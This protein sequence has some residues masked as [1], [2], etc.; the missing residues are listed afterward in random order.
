MRRRKGLFHTYHFVLTIFDSKST[1]VDKGE[2]ETTIKRHGGTVHESVETVWQCLQREPGSKV[3][4]LAPRPSTSPKALLGLSLGSP[5][6]RAS[7]VEECVGARRLVPAGPHALACPCNDGK[8][9][10]QPERH[11]RGSEEDP[12]AYFAPKFAEILQKDRIAV[13]ATEPAGL[14][15]L[16]R[17]V[18]TWL[19]AAPEEHLSSEC[20]VLVSA[21]P[22]G[23]SLAE[24]EEARRHKV[25]VVSHLWVRE[26]LLAQRRTN[27]KPHLVKKP[28][29]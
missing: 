4:V 10:T 14:G 3:V 20:S 21:S 22:E 6:V 2:V 23:P 27:T 8:E 24:W 29:A 1:D 9:C 19:G 16:W 15:N 17:Q 18:T 28:E 13:L 7:W 12:E 11:T 25:P 26:C 5:P